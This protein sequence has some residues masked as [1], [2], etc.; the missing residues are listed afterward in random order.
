[1]LVNTGDLSQPISILLRDGTGE[2]HKAAEAS[3]GA[4]WLVRGELDKDEYVRYLMMLWH[5]YE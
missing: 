3:S 4:G 2:A 5:I 1:M